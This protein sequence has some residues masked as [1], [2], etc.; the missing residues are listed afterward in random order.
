MV[1]AYS[2]HRL[3][4]RYPGGVTASDNLSFDVQ[5][6]EIFG[7]LGP[8]GA[9]KSTLVRQMVGLTRPSS[10]GIRLF[11]KQIRPHDALVR[12]SVSFLAQSPLA[13]LDLT[14]KEAVAYTGMLR[15]LSPQQAE[16][17]AQALLDELGIGDRA[18]RV[19]GRMSGGE[20]RLA[21]LAAALAADP[22]VLILDEPTNELDPVIRSRVWNLLERR[23]R[24]GSTI[25]LVTHN[26]LEAERVVDRVAIM[27]R[28]RIAAIGTPEAL[29]RQLRLQ[30]SLELTGATAAVLGVARELGDV[31]DA[32]SGKVRVRVGGNLGAALQRLADP[33]VFSGLESLR[34][35]HP[36]LE[37]VYLSIHGQP[38]EAGDD[39]A[40]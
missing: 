30:V 22:P 14:V 26:V 20:H 37:D 24:A 4:K 38:E 13:L 21:G 7:I 8:N 35:L 34:V 29:K 11:G 40:V 33:A 2:V 25:V 12:R 6:G 5:Q 17:S 15:G 31:R 3:T 28:G 18:R 19:I 23:R 32:A 1:A 39:R 10:G 16:R 36:S 27:A 9:G